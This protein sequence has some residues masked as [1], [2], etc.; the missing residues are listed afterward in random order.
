MGKD[1]DGSNIKY[2]RANRLY[3]SWLYVEFLEVAAAT[4]RFDVA[5]A[6]TAVK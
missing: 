1:D 5:V 6:A 2:G 3:N 4:T